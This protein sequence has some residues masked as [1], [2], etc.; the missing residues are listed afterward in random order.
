ML[1][2]VRRCLSPK[3]TAPVS[4]PPG[5][6]HLKN[7]LDTGPPAPASWDLTTKRFY[8][9]SRSLLGMLQFFNAVYYNSS[10]NGI[11]AVFHGE[12]PGK[13]ILQESNICAFCTN[14]KRRRLLSGWAFLKHVEIHV[15]STFKTCVDMFKSMFKTFS[16]ERAAVRGAA[17]AAGAAPALVGVWNRAVSATKR[18]PILS[19]VLKDKVNCGLELI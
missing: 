11:K 4:R 17:A 14:C 3:K 5:S 16:Q 9:T 19:L 8:A 7:L 6:C 13:S 1:C 2:G 15:Q 18:T 10:R 12:P